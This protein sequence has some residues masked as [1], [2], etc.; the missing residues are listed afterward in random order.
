MGATPRDEMDGVLDALL[1]FAQQMLD[2][3][4]EFYPYA[5]ALDSSGEVQMVAADVGEEHPD[6]SELIELLYEGLTRQ[7]SAGQ[8]RAAG[9]CADVRVNPPDSADTTDAIK[10]AIEHASSDPVEVFLPYVKRRF[11]GAQYG[12]LFAQAGTARVFSR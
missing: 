2:K 8:I 3:H 1:R 9:V 10:I 4:G 7:A 6:S 5:A 12:E 11:R